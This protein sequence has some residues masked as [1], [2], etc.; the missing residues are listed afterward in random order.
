[1]A[2]LIG[3]DAKLYRGTAGSS[4]STE[5]TNVRDVTMPDSMAEAN[6]SRRASAF[7]VVKPTR[8]TIEVNFTM[9]NDDADA[10]L[11]A[12]RAAYAA[13]TALAFKVLDKTSGKGVDAD[14]YIMKM[15][16]SEPDETEQT[17]AVTIKPTFITRWPVDV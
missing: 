10:D 7:H 8:R 16:R 12:L 14:W 1:M 9:L 5:M 2:A 13:K 3:L 6:I 15:E 17:Y 4:P 11:T